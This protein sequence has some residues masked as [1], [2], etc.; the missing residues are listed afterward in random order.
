[1]QK[2]LRV[3]RKL[4]R[5]LIVAALGFLGLV[6][7]YLVLAV[8]LTLIP[9]NTDYVPPQEGLAVFVRTNG[10]HTGFVLP[11]DGPGVDWRAQ[12]KRT[13]F[14]DPAPLPSHI[15]F[16]WGDKGFYLQ[17]P[18]F[19]DLTIGVALEAMF[20]LGTCAMH[21]G[22]HDQPV[23]NASTKR[24]LLTP[25]QHRILVDHIQASFRTAEDGSWLH[26]AES[27]YR[28]NDTFYEAVGT[29]S[30]VH[31]CNTWTN[32]ALKKMGVKTGVWTPFAQSVMHHLGSAQ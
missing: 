11:L 9:V 3:L 1:M 26:I 14:R 7:L 10:V 25:Q 19:A 4:L 12:A 27:G 6:L 13:H 20:F 15:S 18:T 22:Y 29:Y 28:D 16:G 32:A 31:T 21:V 24:L 2:S 23:E 5:Y 8:V 17:V 30:F